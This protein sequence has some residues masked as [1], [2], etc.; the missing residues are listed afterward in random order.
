MDKSRVHLVNHEQMAEVVGDEINRW[1]LLVDWYN[2][3]TGWHSHILPSKHDKEW[4]VITING[5]MDIN[6]KS[7]RSHWGVT[8]RAL[9]DVVDSGISDIFIL[10]DGDFFETGEDTESPI[11]L[12]ELLEWYIA[13]GVFVPRECKIPLTKDLMNDYIAKYYAGT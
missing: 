4:A 6:K 7:K 8:M 1:Q 2:Q 13:F 9:A 3:G 5:D 10:T 12:S 11:L